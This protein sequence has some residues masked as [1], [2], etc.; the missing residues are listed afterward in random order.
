M[1]LP[2]YNKGKVSGTYP[3]LTVVSERG[4]TPMVCC[5][6]CSA[7]MA[8][9]TAKAGL[10]KSMKNEAHMIRAQGGRAHNA[11]SKA[12]ELREGAKNALGITLKSVARA[13]MTARL[14]AGFAIVAAVQYAKLP[15]PLK[16]QTND[17]GHSVCLFGW[18]ESDDCVGVFDPLWTQGAAGAWSPWSNFNDALW[19]DGSHSSTT[20][21]LVAPTP[22]VVEPTPPIVIPPEVEPPADLTPYSEAD[23]LKA[24][25][26][27]WDAMIGVFPPRPE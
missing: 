23:L 7:H 3:E 26:D 18:R 15:G 2:D 13:D 14:R 9:R 27:V 24:K 10:S 12:S 8:C 19:P 5:G 16:V 1:P 4:E 17:F 21:R 11:G 20:V 6:Y 25:Q 22:P